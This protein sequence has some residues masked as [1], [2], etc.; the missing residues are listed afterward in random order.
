MSHINDI[1]IGIAAFAGLVSAV[2]CVGMCSGI[3]GA[4]TVS[5]PDSIRNDKRRLFSYIAIYNFGR[6][7]S[8]GLAGILLGFFSGVLFYFLDNT[9]ILFL[10]R[11]FTALI[12]LLIGLH[13]L[14][15]FH[16]FSS[17]HVLG[18]RIWSR[19]QPLGQRLLPVK[20]LRQAF[21]FGM[22]WG[23]LPCGLVYSMLLWTVTSGSPL[24]GGLTMFAFG[25]GT[26]PTLILASL[27]STWVFKGNRLRLI[28]GITGSLMII[29]AVGAM[30]VPGHM[31][32]TSTGLVEKDLVP[33]LHHH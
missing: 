11:S 22:V 33:E 23:W 25:V 30:L 16:R 31:T 18:R 19:I 5:L 24:Q 20:D 7:L 1:S 27:L 32:T 4:L 14:G 17:M 15:L 6:I 2:H 26:F 28:K 21:L 10:S 9:T 12:F 3:A 8:Y 13:L 29:L